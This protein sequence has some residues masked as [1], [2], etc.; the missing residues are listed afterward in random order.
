MV[1]VQNDPNDSKRISAEL[2]S[3][4]THEGGYVFFYRPFLDMFFDIL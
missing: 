1:H 3:V 2:V 4:E